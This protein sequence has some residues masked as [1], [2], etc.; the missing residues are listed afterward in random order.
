M[1]KY[2]TLIKDFQKKQDLI[3]NIYYIDTTFVHAIHCKKN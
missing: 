3:K 2:V 1:Q